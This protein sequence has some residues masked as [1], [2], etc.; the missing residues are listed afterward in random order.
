MFFLS[1]YARNLGKKI[2]GI[3]A[4]VT[5][6]LTNYSWPG[7]VRELQN[8]IERALILSTGPI[9][10]LESDLPKVSTAPL[11]PDLTE[12][13]TDVTGYETHSPLKTL[14]EVER[15]HI[16]AVL[17]ETRWVIEGSS[18]A[19]KTLG[20]HPNTLRHRMEKLGIKRA[21][22]RIS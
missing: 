3:S 1:R 17:Q 4:A 7:N 22:H 14:H 18:G 21:S 19:A 9:L 13:V 16:L 20:M 6:R 15:A 10:E 5:E 12:N 11:I 8:V 2:E